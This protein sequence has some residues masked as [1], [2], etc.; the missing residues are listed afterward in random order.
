MAENRVGATFFIWLKRVRHDR[1]ALRFAFLMAV[2]K[3]VTM[4]LKLCGADEVA[5]YERVW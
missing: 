5:H 3:E 2:R 4:L 1:E